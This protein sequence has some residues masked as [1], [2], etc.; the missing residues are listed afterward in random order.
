M[1]DGFLKVKRRTLVI[2]NC[3]AGL[4]SKEKIKGDGQASFHPIIVQEANYLEGNNE[5]AEAPET[6]KNADGFQHDPANGKSLKHH[7]P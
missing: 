6:S 4:N 5:S 7:F 3:E 2:I 1:T